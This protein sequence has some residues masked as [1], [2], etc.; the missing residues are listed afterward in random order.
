MLQ[1]GRSKCT[2]VCLAVVVLLALPWTQ[3]E[4]SPLKKSIKQHGQKEATD[5]TD[6]FQR[7]IIVFGEPKNASAQADPSYQ[8]DHPGFGDSQMFQ[9]MNPGLWCGNNQMR[10]T[11]F[12]RYVGHFTLKQNPPMPLS[13]V[14]PACGYTIEGFP[15]RLVLHVPYDGCNIDIEGGYYNLP[16][17]WNG[18]TV[19]LMCPRPDD[20]QPTLPPFHPWFPWL[21]WPLPQEPTTAAPPVHPPHF[22]PWYY[23]HMHKIPPYFWYFYHMHQI[24]FPGLPTPAPST[25]A[26]PQDPLMYL[27]HMHKIPYPGLP[28]AAAPLVPHV[29][30]H[31]QYGQKIYFP[32]QQQQTQFPITTAAPNMHCP[33]C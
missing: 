32:Q 16:L 31:S 24:P 9:S 19:K 26:A 23:W 1:K 11:A 17:L 2:E 14:P 3:T 30:K 33:W 28:P 5:S 10:F 29:H 7:G 8:A 12:G 4:A 25:T 18:H 22:H 20:A 6:G 21:P 27:Y 13:Q 15:H